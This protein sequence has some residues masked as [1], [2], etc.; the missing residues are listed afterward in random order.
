MVGQA[1]PPHGKARTPVD[2]ERVQSELKTLYQWSSAK[3][4][5]GCSVHPCW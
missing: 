2:G 4:H 3:E 1:L 5:V